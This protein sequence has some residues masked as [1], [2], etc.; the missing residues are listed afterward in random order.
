[1]LIVDRLKE[2]LQISETIG[3]KALNHLVQMG[4]GERFPDECGIWVKEVDAIRLASQKDLE[5]QQKKAQ[6]EL[7]EA[8]AQME[9]SIRFAVVNAVF[10]GYPFVAISCSGAPL[11]NKHIARSIVADASP[12]TQL[13]PLLK[14][15]D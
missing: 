8:R 12:V 9:S 14:K 2:R 10:S 13:S 11:T 6:D 7:S 4:I 5:A 15:R 3:P 1:M